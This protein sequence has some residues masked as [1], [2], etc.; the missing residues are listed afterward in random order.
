MLPPRSHTARVIELNPNGL[1]RNFPIIFCLLTA[2]LGKGHFGESTI[3]SYREESPSF[4]P[5]GLR[6]TLQ[7]GTPQLC[8]GKPLNFLLSEF[9]RY[10]QKSTKE[11]HA[12][13]DLNFSLIKCSPNKQEIPSIFTCFRGSVFGVFSPFIGQ[14]EIIFGCYVASKG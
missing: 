3:S 13:R 8:G 12:C 4:Q 9:L 7:A 6:D 2:E 5:K 14:L 1:S 10:S 11:R